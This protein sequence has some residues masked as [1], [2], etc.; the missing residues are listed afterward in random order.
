[1]IGC[2]DVEF[3]VLLPPIL[4]GSC[5]ILSSPRPQGALEYEASSAAAS[6]VNGLPYAET[7]MLKD[8]SI[9]STSPSDGLLL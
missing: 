6:R 4:T 3:G 5:R 7:Y 8:N 2:V 1:M 9:L